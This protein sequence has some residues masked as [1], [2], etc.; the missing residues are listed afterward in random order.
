MTVVGGQPRSVWLLPFA[1]AARAELLTLKHQ[2]LAPVALMALGF[3]PDGTIYT[4]R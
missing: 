3:F 1:V 4:V 2:V